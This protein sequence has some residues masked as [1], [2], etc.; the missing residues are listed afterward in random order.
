MSILRTEIHVAHTP[1]EAEAIAIGGLPHVID[2]HQCASCGADV[3]CTEGKFTPI[4]IILNEDSDWYACMACV[5]PA[6]WP[7][8]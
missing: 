3:G 5:A 8:N 1:E 6:L 2:Q 7:R 4:A